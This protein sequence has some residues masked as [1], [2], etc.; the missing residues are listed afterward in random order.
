MRSAP[1]TF[2]GLS[3][4]LLACPAPQDQP[5][6]MGPSSGPQPGM[7]GPNGDVPGPANPGSPDGV[8]SQEGAPPPAA[9]E[10]GVPP[11]EGE[12]PPPVRG[13]IEGFSGE[14]S[15][16]PDS[17][18]AGVMVIL[19]PVRNQET[20]RGGA[21]FALSGTV[22]GSCDGNLRIDVL[23]ATPASEEA[24]QVGPLSAVELEEAGAFEVAVP[25]GD[26]V[27]LSAI[28]DVDK[29]DRIGMGDMLSAPGGAM[30]LSSAKSG[31]TL[32]LEPLAGVPNPE[33]G[34]LEKD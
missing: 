34:G 8:A 2:A 16:S 22:E 13:H 29:D 31:I 30:G 19:Q 33:E 10:D 32:T 24:G 25:E 6:T 28:C 14:H 18:E 21:H 23:S 12:L 1:L 5:A 26:T 27:E 20:I 17:K 7:P 15:G 11:E 4:L 9:G 3:L